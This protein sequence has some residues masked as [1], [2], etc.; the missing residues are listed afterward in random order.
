MKKTLLIIFISYFIG[1]CE[2]DDICLSSIPDT[3][4]LTIGFFDEASGLKKDVTNLKIQGDG[5][6]KNYLIKTTD[7]ISI[8]LKNL[9]NMS[10]FF[11]VKDFDEDIEGS[12][13]NDHV[14]FNYQNNHIYISRA[15]GYISNYELKKIIIENDNSNWIIKSEIT[16]PTVI[17]EKAIHVKIFH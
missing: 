9:D 14:L 5:I 13:N 6:E 2:P 1:S 12:G 4:K 16:N 7:S 15:C 10:G 8:P 3:P 11:F 17:N